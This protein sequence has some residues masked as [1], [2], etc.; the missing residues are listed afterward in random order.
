[1]ITIGIATIPSRESTL[2]RVLYSLVPQADQIML[3]LNGYKEIP[4]WLCNYANVCRAIGSNSHGDAMKFSV[5]ENVKGYYIGWD[6]DLE[7]PRGCAKYLCDGVDKY[8]GLISLHGRTYL[9]PITSFRK[10]E[11]N[12]RCLNAVSEDVKVN[13]IGSGCCC[14][15]TDR[16]KVTLSDFKTKNKAD[17]YLSKLA[18]EQDVPMVVLAHQSSYLTYTNPESTIWRSTESFDE[19]TKILQSFIK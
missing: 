8:N 2:E 17:L 18:T 14:F 3:V 19:H 12:Y 10:W 16:L 1:M 5:A 9:K 15:H 6:D 13:L 7:M 11:G 4:E